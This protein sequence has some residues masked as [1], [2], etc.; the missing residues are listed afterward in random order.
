MERGVVMN[1][2]PIERQPIT[3]ITRQPVVSNNLIV[4]DSEQSNTNFDQMLAE[5]QQL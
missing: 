3:G 1:R 2:Q 5:V 4:Q